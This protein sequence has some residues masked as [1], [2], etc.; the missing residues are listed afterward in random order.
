MPARKGINWPIAILSVVITTLLV[1]HLPLLSALVEYTL[2]GTSHVEDYC[3]RMGIHDELGD[4]YEP[5]VTFAQD[6]F[7]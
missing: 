6:L 3:R 5:I 4:L 7:E 1:L 2:F